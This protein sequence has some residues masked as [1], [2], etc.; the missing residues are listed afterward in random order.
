MDTYN[1]K[2]H[3][4]KK[5]KWDIDDSSIPSE[6]SDVLQKPCQKVLFNKSRNGG[7]NQCKTVVK[8]GYKHS[9][10]QSLIDFSR[11]DMNHFKKT[12]NEAAELK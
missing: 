4:P 7:T 9:R 1:T 11:I 3:S 6:W 12:T 5:R 2:Q 8:I 10:V